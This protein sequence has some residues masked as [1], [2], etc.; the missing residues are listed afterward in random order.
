LKCLPITYLYIMDT[1]LIYLYWYKLFFFSASVL[2]IHIYY[3]AS[4]LLR[5]SIVW[6]REKITVA[7]RTLVR[8]RTSTAVRHRSK[9]ASTLETV[10]LFCVAQLLDPETYQ[11]PMYV[12][13]RSFAGLQTGAVRHRS[14]SV[15]MHLTNVLLCAGHQD[16]M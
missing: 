10:I 6:P 11:D 15:C 1:Y 13:L 2:V 8:F 7:R 5:Y 16:P 9:P 3:I 12:R 14:K 4:R